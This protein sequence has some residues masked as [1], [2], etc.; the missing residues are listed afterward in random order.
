MTS[1]LAVLK[2]RDFKLYLASRFCA[3][4]AT[5]MVIMA[6]G[7]QVYH[8]TGRVLDL[9]LIGL[10]QFLPFLCLVLFAGHVADQF[11]RR[12]IIM[13][14]HCAYAICTVL[15]LSF[16]WLKLRTTLPIFTV[17]AFLGITRAFQMPAAQSFVPT[18]VTTANLRN[19][20]ALNSSANQVA[21]I[22]GPSVGGIV[23][24][25]AEGLLGPNT[26]AGV[27]YGAAAILVLAAIV[28][29]SLIRKRRV[30]ASRAT[31]SWS[32]LL[33]GL[34]FV[35]HRKTVLGAIS[36]DLFAVLF[37]GATALLPAYTREVLHAGPDVFGYLRAAP[38]IGAGAMA[39]WLAFRPISRHVGV[40][41]FAGV[42]AFGM[43]TVVLGL[44][45]LFWVALIALVILGMGDM[46]SVFVRSLLVQLQ[47]PDEIRGRVSAVTS[48]FIGTSNELGEFE[49]GTT[50]AWFG[51][52][53]AIV[54]GGVATMVITVLWARVFFPALGRMQT[55]EH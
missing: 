43:A 37:G 10:S 32:T 42:G 49:S 18:I 36:L 40:T 1:G 26:G 55:F 12:L 38:G 46:I 28:L 13:L 25:I 33:S 22:L 45:H 4:I 39:L 50:A 54:I 35:W 7:W 29:V 34:H 51:L 16:A 47:T 48:V 8:I 24:A 6:V 53:P 15:L 30:A 20:L 3:S 41:M 52:V 27:V 19:A 9:G 2:N 44:T 5:Q 14:G 23:Y 11:D 21:S 31:L 17:L